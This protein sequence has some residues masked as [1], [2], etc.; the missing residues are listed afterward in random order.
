MVKN[1]KSYFSFFGILAATVN[2]KIHSQI[3]IIASILSF[4]MPK[5]MKLLHSKQL[6]PVKQYSTN[7][8]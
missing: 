6:K 4:D 1:R 7:N 3:S 5:I 2:R 8:I